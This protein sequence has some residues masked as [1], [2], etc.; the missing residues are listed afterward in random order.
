MEK[1]RYV[2]KYS[3]CWKINILFFLEEVFLLVLF[4]IERIKEYIFFNVLG[5]ENIWFKNL[6]KCC[7]DI[8]VIDF[9]YLG[10]D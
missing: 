10:M 2:M 3:N 4:M 1:K 8:M 5:I 6:N 7:S 9:L